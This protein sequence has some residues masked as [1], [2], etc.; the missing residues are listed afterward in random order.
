MV[1]FRDLAQEVKEEV[2]AWRRE[3]HR[4]PE[5]SMQEFR[6]AERV[7][8]ELRKMG[9]E[10]CRHGDTAV[11]GILKGAKPGKTVALRADMDALSLTEEND[12]PYASEV[13]GVMHACG[14]DAHVATLLG[15]AKVLSQVRDQLPGTVKF[16]FQ[17]GEEVAQGAKLIVEA[18][19]MDDVDAVFG[20]HVWADLPAGQIS[21]EP[22]PRMAFCD[23][24]KIHVT[25]KGG[26]A[27]QPH[28]TIDA[29][30]AS[31]ATIMNLQSI[32]SR[33]VSPLDNLVVTI[34]KVDV[35][36]RWNI[37][38][39]KGTLEGTV[40]GFCPELQAQAPGII[41]RIAKGTAAAYR[42]EV[43]MEYAKLTP[44]TMNDPKLSEMA[45]DMVRRLYGE[46]ALA[47]IPKQT[48][49]EDFAY[50]CEKAPGVFAFL[51]VANEEN[52]CY[53]HHHPKFDVDEGALDRGVALYAQFAWDFLTGEGK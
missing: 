44:V 41:E 48:G 8:E 3:L 35:G 22:G 36:T 40:R 16:F 24:F 29:V 23:M 21:V 52:A 32:V 50:Y 5:V 26:H 42:A 38:A 12:V 15:A 10:I 18:G 39:G 19:E 53:P 20:I 31:A 25:G 33:E 30:V 2:I 11:I 1:C 9:I 46:E 47:S 13:E 17:P 43:E 6:T 37:I 7:E 34:G 28:Q 27:A 45:T 51:G 4:H 49:S 14:H